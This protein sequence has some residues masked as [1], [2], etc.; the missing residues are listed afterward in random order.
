MEVLLYIVPLVIA[1]LIGSIPFGLLLTRWAGL[2]DIR[3]IG[4]GNIGATNVLRT[5]KKWLALV[6]LL[7]DFGKAFLP[8]YFALAIGYT[9]MVVFALD[10]AD[11]TARQAAVEQS[12][13]TA[14]VLSMGAP[15]AV[16]LGHMFP[17]WLRFKGGKGVACLFG[18]FFAV[19]WVLGVLA[20]VFW[21][22]IF[23]VTRYSSL[24]ALIALP[25][26]PVVIGFLYPE[27]ID[28]SGYQAAWLLFSLILP[29]LLMIMKH[30][31]NI[32]RLLRGEENRFQSSKT[33]EAAE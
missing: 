25:L 27:A 22:T 16:I 29:I 23:A 18:V 7:L 26:A 11:S 28:W 10:A 12:Q 32:R 4:S 9:F 24:S 21:L 19:S 5:G 15:L 2:G 13:L 20:A 31:E 30:R 8:T 33:A 14:M 3:A 17:V 1:Y 6:T